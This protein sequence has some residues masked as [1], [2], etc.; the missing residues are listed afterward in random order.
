VQGGGEREGSALELMLIG[1]TFD[2]AEPE[3]AAFLD[4]AVLLG[5]G[6]VRI[7]HGKGTGALRSK[8]RAY[9]RRHRKVTEFYPPRR[10]PAATA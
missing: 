4:N 3:L 8:V 2:E 10:N 7:V 5:L 6:K 9:L 1:K